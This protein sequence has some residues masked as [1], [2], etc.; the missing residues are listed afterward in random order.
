M[1][2]SASRT[3]V[4]ATKVGM[5]RVFGEGGRHI[6]V[7]VLKLDNCRVVGQRTED[8]DGYTALQIGYGVAKTKRV[9]KANRT[10]FGKRNVEPPQKVV[11]FRVPADALVDV[12]AEI[13]AD[14]FVPGQFVDLIGTSKGKGFAG[15]MKR[16]G[17]AGLR[18]SHGVS[19]SHRS[20]GSTGQNQDPGRVF[21]GKK[22]AG[23]MGDVRV[24]AQNL[25]IVATDPERDVILVKGAVPGAKGGYVLV[26]DAI[27]CQL[28]EG[29]PFPA[30][31]RTAGVA[32]ADAAPADD[33][34][35]E[36]SEE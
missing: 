4:V 16:H 15:A 36:A 3:G 21:K 25:E 8:L 10:A 22:M 28:P 12:G 19:I 5:T 26:S 11:E 20:H 23:H 9:S 35:T 6:P 29:V 1:S 27:K 30:A 24:T 33:N 2:K 17:F 31:I 18:A 32:A 7:T 14:H 34:G 13:G